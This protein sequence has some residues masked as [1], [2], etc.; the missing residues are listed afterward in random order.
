VAVGATVKG[1]ALGA[2]AAGVA[3]MLAKR[4]A[5]QREDREDVYAERY[6]AAGGRE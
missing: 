1:A 3:L 2:G 5:Q 4:L 6:E